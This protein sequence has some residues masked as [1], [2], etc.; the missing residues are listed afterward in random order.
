MCTDWSQETEKPIPLITPVYHLTEW[1][2]QRA[3]RDIAAIH[4]TKDL[5][6]Q[7]HPSRRFLT[8]EECDTSSTAKNGIFVVAG[9]PEELYEMQPVV[10]GKL[11]LFVGQ[12]ITAIE[13]QVFDPNVHLTLSIAGETGRLSADGFVREDVPRFHGMSGGGIWRVANDGHS[14]TFQLSAIQHR[15]LH[16]SYTIGTRT[17]HVIDRIRMDFPNLGES[18]LPFLP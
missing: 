8:I 5:V 4:L 18:K 2:S 3:V 17:I 9:F 16:G 6:K 12:E 10:V 15:T 14:A 7:F 11:M 13:D 1:A